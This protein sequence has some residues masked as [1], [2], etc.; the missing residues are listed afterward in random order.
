MKAKGI[1][2]ERRNPRYRQVRYIWAGEEEEHKNE[3]EKRER[4]RG[5]NEREA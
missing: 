5:M 1:P 2:R 4:G 3:K